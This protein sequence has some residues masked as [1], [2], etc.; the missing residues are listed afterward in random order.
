[1]RAL[2]WARSQF[3]KLAGKTFGG[4]RDVEFA[5]GYKHDL[6]IQDYRRRFDRG[7][8]ANQ[9]VKARPEACWRGGPELIEDEDPTTYTPF[10]QAFDDLNNRLKIW[11]NL[12]SVDVLSGIG[13]YGIVIIGAPGKTD[14]PLEKVSPDEVA[15][16]QPYSEEDVSV[17]QWDLDQKSPRYGHPELY[18]LNSLPGRL[19]MGNSPRSTAVN[20][21][22]SRVLHVCETMLEDKVFGPPRLEAIWNYLDDLDKVVGGGSEATWNLANS[23]IHFRLD[24][25][26]TFGTDS[27]DADT[28]NAKQT[29][30]MQQLT[31]EIEKYEHGLKRNLVT[32]GIEAQRIG[33][34][35][36][37]FGGNKDAIIS[38][39]SATTRIPQRVLQGSEQAKLAGES[40]RGNWDDQIV[41]RQ[42]NYVA[43]ML[44]R[45]LIDRLIAWGTLPKPSEYDVSWPEL[46]VMDDEQRA[47]VAVS[48]SQLNH[49]AGS[50][51]V[52]PNE[53][54]TK[55]LGL[56]ELS[57]SDAATMVKATLGPVAAR[58]FKVLSRDKQRRFLRRAVLRLGYSPTQER[59][60]HGRWEDGGGDGP[61]AKDSDKVARAKESYKV[62]DKRI[63]AM[64]TKGENQVIEMIKGE[65][66]DD[67][68]PMDVLTRNAG[69][70]RAH[71]VEV[72]TLTT[73]S[74]DKI[75]MHKSSLE[76]KEKFVAKERM[77]AHTVVIDKR[78]G[79][80]DKVYYR[81]GLGSFRL[82]TMEH[83][84]SGK[85]LKG[86]GSTLR[87]RMRKA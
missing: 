43:P 19:N 77:V 84:G 46:K 47:A 27:D 17:F 15:Y 55:V 56:E 48:W 21:H 2:S 13:R 11:R 50:P 67:N 5:L 71:A 20:F 40:D 31:A 63:R 52:T 42:G 64:A 35:I 38:L 14:E 87:G 4:K 58:K 74:N 24:P 53:I 29:T 69:D 34:A 79:G 7:G 32:R 36:A 33:S 78:P 23:G 82:H 30:A 81:Q 60:Y 85:D 72:K 57:E 70:G 83:I 86:T 54:R 28:L 75:T 37:D 80:G 39:I 12:Q 10:E 59:D 25:E 22:H 61:A 41:E 73:N 66:T 45:P 8:I 51:V 76:R 18:S 65:K 3:A 62:M 16:L 6:F 68:A 44:V 1:M 9:V 49:L 26:V